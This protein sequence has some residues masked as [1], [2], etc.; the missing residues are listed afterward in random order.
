MSQFVAWLREWPHRP[1]PPLRARDFFP[2]A[3]RLFLPLYADLF[4]LH[5]GVRV[6][7]GPAQSFRLGGLLALTGGTVLTALIIL[8]IRRPTTA[9]QR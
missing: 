3:G 1:R 8:Y 6:L 9:P 5:G 2:H 4:L 7:F